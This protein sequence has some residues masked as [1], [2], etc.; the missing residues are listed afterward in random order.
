MVESHVPSKT[1]LYG[2]DTLP[3]RANSLNLTIFNG[4]NDRL[5]ESKLIK[6]GEKKWYT[7]MR[8]NKGKDLLTKEEKLIEELNDKIDK[9]YENEKEI[10]KYEEEINCE[11]NK[12]LHTKKREN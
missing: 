3:R 12:F 11:E 4:G 5:E 10:R 9:I 1:E 8:K 6:G 2:G 7:E